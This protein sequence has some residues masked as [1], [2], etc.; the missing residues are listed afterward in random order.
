MRRTVRIAAS[1]LIELVPTHFRTVAALW[2]SPSI[3]ASRISHG[4]CE[5]GIRIF[6]AHPWYPK[7]DDPTFG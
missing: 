2:I 3:F 4:S 6:F 7:K 5:T 1:R